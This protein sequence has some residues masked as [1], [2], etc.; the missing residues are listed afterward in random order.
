MQSASEFAFGSV[1]RCVVVPSAAGGGVA[2]AVGPGVASVE[3]LTA[4]A[5]TLAISQEATLVQAAAADLASGLLR[6]RVLPVVA[7]DLVE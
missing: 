5:E 7:A 3:M 4:S 1:C 2:G 6:L